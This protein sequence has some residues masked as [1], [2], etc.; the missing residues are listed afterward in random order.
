MG[1][2]NQTSLNPNLLVQFWTITRQRLQLPV[3]FNKTPTLKVP[4]LVITTY[5]IGRLISDIFYILYF[6]SISFNTY[7]I[8]TGHNSKVVLYLRN[9]GD[10]FK[11][12]KQKYP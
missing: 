8:R 2:R 3:N 10:E 9:N 4:A 5:F 12:R 6:I 11:T 7:N 1:K